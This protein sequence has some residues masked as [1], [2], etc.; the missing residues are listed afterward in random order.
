MMHS[1]LVEP[2]EKPV[3]FVDGLAPLPEESW[4]DYLDRAVAWIASNPTIEARSF[5]NPP[6]SRAVTAWAAYVLTATGL[7]GIVA[8]MEGLI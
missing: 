5:E 8:H 6:L 4:A 3:V 7:L 1:D 2:A